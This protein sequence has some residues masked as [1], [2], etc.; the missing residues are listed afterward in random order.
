MM[1]K[2]VNGGRVRADAYVL[3]D[4]VPVC[5][6]VDLSGRRDRSNLGTFRMTFVIVAL[7]TI[8]SLLI[9][10]HAFDEGE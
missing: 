1:T 7:M 3:K 5:E 4:S 9:V 8:V 10:G 2:P 6:R